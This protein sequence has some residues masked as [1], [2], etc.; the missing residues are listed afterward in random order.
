ML[1][2]AILDGEKVVLNPGASRILR[3]GDIAFVIA[4]DSKTI[5]KDSELRVAEYGDAFIFVN[6]KFVKTYLPADDAGSYAALGDRRGGGAEEERRRKKKERRKRRRAKRRRKKEEAARRKQQG[7][8]DPSKVYAVGGGGGDSD[9][10]DASPSSSSDEDDADSTSNRRSR[11]VVP[12]PRYLLTIDAKAG[13]VTDKDG[14]GGTEGGGAA[15]GEPSE[16]LKRALRSTAEGQDW[17]NI[18]VD[19]YVRYPGHRRYMMTGLH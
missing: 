12:L 17:R 8:G 11:R 7:G 16:G 19:L 6:G 14:G 13:G 18:G 5:T 15:G 9:E 10:D 1:L 2:F 4:E 3:A